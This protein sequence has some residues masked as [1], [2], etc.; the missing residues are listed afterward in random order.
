VGAWEVE[1][2]AEA[3]V[4]TRY[5]A[6]ALA[7]TRCGGGRLCLR[8]E[9]EKGSSILTFFLPIASLPMGRLGLI[10]IWV[11]PSRSIICYLVLSLD[12]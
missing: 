12:K 7:Y 11:N 1:E 5:K 6:A 4:C 9:F 10:C 8:V 2:A 3:A